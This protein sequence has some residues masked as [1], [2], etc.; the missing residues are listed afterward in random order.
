MNKL[1]VSL[2]IVAGLATALVG[3]GCAKSASDIK[4]VPTALSMTGSSQSTTLANYKKAHPLLQLLA[5]TAVALAPPAMT[6]SGTRVIALNK[7]WVI[8]KEIEFKLAEVAGAAEVEGSEVK[9]RGP[10]FVDLLS[11]TPASFGAAEV[12]AGV[13]RRVK[14]K[15]EKD[16]SIPAGLGAPA[17][18]SGNSIYLEGNVSGQPFSYSAPDGTEFKIAGPG[19]VTLTETS[20]MVIG[21]KVSDL[22]RLINMD[23]VFAATNRNIS[24]ANRISTGSVSA[25]PLIDNSLRDIAACFRKGL[26]KAGKFGKDSDNDGEIE[27][28]DDEVQD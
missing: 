23:A 18:L 14:M 24:D 25:C 20:N 13:Y 28:G 7:A 26:E 16:S 27:A 4:L 8:V 5:P 1:N 3:V 21:V 22:F 17:Q 6:D 2:K 12:P 19:G 10:Y 11:T 9:F 15:L